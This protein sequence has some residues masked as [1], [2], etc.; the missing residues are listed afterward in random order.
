G[1]IGASLPRFGP[2][3]P[4]QTIVDIRGYGRG[5]ASPPGQTTA[6][7]V[8]HGC[9][10]FGAGVLGGFARRGPFAGRG[11]LGGGGYRGMGAGLGGGM[12][13]AP[14]RHRAAGQGVTVTTRYRGGL[15]AGYR[16]EFP[17]S[18]AAVGESVVVVIGLWSDQQ[19]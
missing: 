11:R 10:L 15:A 14:G 1:D 7:D 4:G 17:G 8:V 3:L 5:T 16:G 6:G 13:T 19:C 18:R 9:P 12:R 2:G